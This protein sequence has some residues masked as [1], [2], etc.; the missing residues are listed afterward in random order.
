MAG[1]NATPDLDARGFAL[2]LFNG[3]TPYRPTE[4]R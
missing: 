2:S 4:I 1:A 3:F